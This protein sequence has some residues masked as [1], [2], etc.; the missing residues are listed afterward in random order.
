LKP[1]AVTGQVAGFAFGGSMVIADLIDRRIVQ[2]VEEEAVISL[3]RLLHFIYKGNRDCN[4]T[5]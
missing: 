1:K 4:R 5:T 3:R 2:M